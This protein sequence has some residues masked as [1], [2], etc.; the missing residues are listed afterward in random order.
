MSVQ[1][2]AFF[3]R[4]PLDALTILDG[5]NNVPA[6]KTSTGASGSFIA[7][8]VL[9]SYW[10]AGDIAEVLDMAV[11]VQTTAISGTA[12]TVTYSVQV[13]PDAG[14]F[15]SPVTIAESGAVTGTG[16]TVITVDRESIIS[17]LGS[18]GPA[19][20]DTVSGSFATVGSL[21]LMVTIGGTSPS[22]SYTAYVSPLTGL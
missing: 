9:D 3:N 19:T 12:A 21:R 2:S 11:V 5:A 15:G 13:A 22:V 8:D 17:A 16:M 1:S 20:Q 4:Y 14:T 7:L 18:S 10:S 6:T